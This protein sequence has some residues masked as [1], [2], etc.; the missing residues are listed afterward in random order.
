[1]AHQFEWDTAKA[2]QNYRKHRISF[3]E[4]MAVFSDSRSIVRYDTEGSSEAEDR[5][6]IV[7]MSLELRVLVVVFVAMKIEY[8]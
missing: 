3:L 2:G 7:G 1:M 8:A 4:A 6:L 5:W